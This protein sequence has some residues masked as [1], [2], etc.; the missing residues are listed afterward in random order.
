METLGF[1]FRLVCCFNFKKAFGK[2]DFSPVSLW[3][4]IEKIPDRK[5]ARFSDGEL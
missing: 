5:M 4:K 2:L 1:L 3:K